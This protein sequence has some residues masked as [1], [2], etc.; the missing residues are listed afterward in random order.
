V[1]DYHIELMLGGIL[2]KLAEDR[3]A[4]NSINVG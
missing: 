4:G 2:E 1:D 3:A